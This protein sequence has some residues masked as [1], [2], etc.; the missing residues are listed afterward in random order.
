MMQRNGAEYINLIRDK[1]EWAKE[2][3]L[4]RKCA[5]IEELFYNNKGKTYDT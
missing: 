4:S 2:E 1:S 5:E 3:S